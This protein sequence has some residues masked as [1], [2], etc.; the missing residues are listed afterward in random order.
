PPVVI[1]DQ[2]SGRWF[3]S[4]FVISGNYTCIAV[5]AS[6][7]P[8]GSWCAYEYQASPTEFPDYPKFGVWPSQNAYF[9]TATQFSFSFDGFGV[10]GFERD[11]MLA[12]QSA[13]MVYQDMSQIDAY[14]PYIF[15]AD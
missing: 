4:Q 13:R 9:M 5:S 6:S 2:Y 3:A 10:W 7:D 15:P 8:T 12:C 1:Y 11:R 14:L